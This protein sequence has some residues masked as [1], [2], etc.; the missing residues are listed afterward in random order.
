MPLF[1][2]R[3]D[4]VLRAGRHRRE[5]GEKWAHYREQIPHL[6]QTKLLATVNFTARASEGLAE[7]ANFFAEK[8]LDV[9]DRNCYT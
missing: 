7:P 5:P 2:P 4:G 8:I 9:A 1:R 6:A 3:K